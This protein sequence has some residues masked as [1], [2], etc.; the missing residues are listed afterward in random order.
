LKNFVPI[1][2]IEV[3]NLFKGGDNVKTIGRTLKHLRELKGV[4][5][6]QMAE[7]LKKYDVNPSKSMISRWENDKADPSMEYAKVLSLY[8]NVTLDELIGLVELQHK[9]PE[10]HT[11]AA[12]ATE[13]LTDE[14]QEEVIKFVQFLKSKRSFDE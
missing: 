13:D 14:E 3:Y 2:T 5:M 12:H 4:S 10:I 6:D 1:L 11:L 7:D 8:F 9:E